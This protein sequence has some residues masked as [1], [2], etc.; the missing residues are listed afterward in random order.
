MKHN[1]HEYINL[2]LSVMWA[3]CDIGSDSPVKHGF[4]YSFGAINKGNKYYKRNSN[5]PLHRDIAR[6]EW[7][8]LWRLPTEGE[9]KE[10][11]DSCKYY[12]CYN[13]GE[14]FKDKVKLLMPSDGFYY[15]NG[16]NNDCF[17]WSST[18]SETPLLA[19]ALNVNKYKG[20]SI[21]ELRKNG[22]CMV[23]PVFKPEEF[24]PEVL[25]IKR[26]KK[27]K[28]N[29]TLSYVYAIQLINHFKEKNE[30]SSKEYG[31]LEEIIDFIDKNIL[32]NFVMAINYDKV[33]HDKCGV[34]FFCYKNGTIGEITIKSDDT[35]E[36]YFMCGDKI[37]EEH[38]GEYLLDK[39]LKSFYILNSLIDKFYLPENSDELI[40]RNNALLNYFT[41]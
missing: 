3:A 40:D 20:G 34:S 5:L 11:I 29:D 36:W 22:K 18:H 2:G 10:L 7:G 4:Y 31:K 6:L 8:G 14:F 41:L 35:F 30:I 32:A 12:C 39:V 38:K 26:Q 1:G 21:V 13:T 16:N 15:M 9:M 37:I 23:R 24:K 28:N 27:I 17:Y 19:K 33:K 25:N